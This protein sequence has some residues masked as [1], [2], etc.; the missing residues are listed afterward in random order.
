[1]ADKAFLSSFYSKLALALISSFLLIG[2]LLVLFVQQ[3]SKNYQSEVEQKL[4]LDLAGHLIYDSPQ[5][6]S[7][8]IDQAALKD[9]FH[10][11]M[12]LGPSF[13][14]YH[15]DTQ[16][17]IMTYDAEPGRVKREM[18]DLA[19]I[20][21]FINKSETLPIWG[22][23]PRHEER[24]KIFSVAEI[25]SE[26]GLEGYLY[27]IIGGEVYDGVVDLIENSHI[28]TIG[29]WLIGAAV[30]FSMLVTLL[31]FGFLTRPLRKLSQ[32][33]T[34]LSQ[35]GFEQAE[36]MSQDQQ[37]WD[38]L[39]NDE[40]EQLGVNFHKMAKV[41]SN[42]YEQIKS[43][44]EL[45]RELISYVSH[46]LRTPLAS[47]QGYLETWQLNN[48]NLD[49]D[50]A[51]SL[52][53][54]AAKNAQQVSR[55]VEQLFE[56][57]HLD[58]HT[59]TL[60]KEPVVITELAYDVVQS[61]SMDAE[62][63]GVRLEVE[64]SHPNAKVEAN[65]ERLERVFTNL[66][67]NAIRHCTSGDSIKISISINQQTNLCPNSSGEMVC[68][69]ISD[70]GAGIPQEDLKFV[71]DNHYRASNSIKGNNSGS[72]LG[73]AITRRILNLHGSAIHVTST[74]DVGTCFSFSLERTP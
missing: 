24:K 15:L 73:L 39:S 64:S 18:V 11:M 6:K 74:L 47:L 26:Q 61:K 21:A 50:S 55:L 48:K 67:D 25:R 2:F 9:T 58:S 27:I 32:E 20:K 56:L 5:L 38:A 34:L 54:I 4:H 40:I 62:Q 13:E 33:M 65:M 7:G 42:Q 46:D 29:M 60:E 23:D 44:D 53:N 28:A 30:V 8:Q 45:R 19:P 71:F 36:K 31:L 57:A 70:T 69:Q 16:G 72:G 37:N 1:V 14:F 10:T 43:T 68:I 52:I 59:I 63:K 41:L 17:N 35:R 49:S 12:I 3:L 22:D 51:E 66:I